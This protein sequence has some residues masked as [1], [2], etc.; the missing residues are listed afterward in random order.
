MSDDSP[1]YANAQKSHALEIKVE[2]KLTKMTGL[3]PN[4]IRQRMNGNAVAFL[5]QTGQRGASLREALDVPDKP[6]V[7]H[8]PPQ[9]LPPRPFSET[10]PER[11]VTKG[12]EMTLLL[13]DVVYLDTSTNTLYYTDLVSTG[14]KDAV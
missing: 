10:N 2:R 1:E 13:K 8:S 14:R 5:Q 11:E 3:T 9:I 12:T 4:Q 6:S 7:R